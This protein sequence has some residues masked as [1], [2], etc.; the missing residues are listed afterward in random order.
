MG[1]SLFV[2]IALFARSADTILERFVT[3]PSGSAQARDLFVAAAANML[4]D[5]PF[6]GPMALRITVDH[7]G[8]V[9]A[10]D[11]GHKL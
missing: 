9:R 10:V 6:G 8:I 2:G 3:A 5:H 1:I 11:L 4:E 7:D